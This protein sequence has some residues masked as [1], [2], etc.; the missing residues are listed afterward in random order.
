MKPQVL[1]FVLLTLMV[2]ACGQDQPSKPR[3]SNPPNTP[4]AN[5]DKPCIGASGNRK[6]AYFGDLHTHT[7]FSLDA[8]FF[9]AT[10]DPRAAH[11]FAQ[12]KDG[13]LPTLGSDDP[14]TP[15]R[16]VNIGRP[17][18]FNAVTDHAEFLGGF[19]N[20]C[21]RNSM[22]QKQCDERI[23]KGIRDDVI[24]IAAGN[25]SLQQQLLQSLVAFAPT[26]ISAWQNTKQ[27]NDDEYVPCK[28]TTLHAYEFTSNE[29]SQMFH[30]NVIFKGDTTRIPLI[31]FPAVRPDT[32]LNPQNGNDDWDLFDHLKIVCKSI[33]GCDVLTIPHNGNLSDGRMWLPMEANGVPLGRKIDSTDIYLPM[34]AADASLRRSMDVA[35]E[36]TQHKGQSECAVGLEGP[37][38]QGEETACTFETFKTVC[39][40]RA[41]DPA[42]CAKFCKGDP[43]TDPNFCNHRSLGDN[44][45]DTC[46]NPGP[47]G[48]SRPSRNPTAT[49]TG[50]CTSALDYYRYAMAE[51]LAIRKTLGINPY[52]ANIVAASDTHNGISGNVGERGFVGHGGVLDDEPKELLGFWN[53]T[54]GGDPAD[55]T[56][57]VG[58]KFQDFARTLNP[59]GLTGVWA[60]QNKRNEIWDAIHRGESW[61]TSGPRIKIR[62]IGGWKL[63][64]NTCDR[65]AAGQNP[66][67]LGETPGALMGGDLPLPAI[68]APQIAVWA[69]Q[70]P[71][72]YPLQRIDIVKGY[73]DASGKP[74]VKVFENVARTKE[75]VKRPSMTDCSVEIGNHPEQL[76]AI[77]KD[78]EFNPSQDAYYYARALEVPSCRWSSYMC[79]VDKKVD[80]SLLNPV[81]G[82][83]P[84]S[85]GF[86]GYEGCCATTGT[87]GSFKGRNT[88]NTIEER[89]WASPIWYEQKLK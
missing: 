22:L 5:D 17:L 24:N 61:G 81:N 25:T 31:V 53:C 60:T 16:A 71:E 51:G 20:T 86:S 11:E 63:P 35:V 41:D 85:T 33:P 55:P 34:T 66:V 42:T 77:W 49:G 54:G 58:R 47:D 64:A 50:N 23:G 89:A 18:D 56:K 8:Y 26:S 46:L 84:A 88:F 37:Y 80:C 12:G 68:G 3:V 27:I 19:S 75:T 82:M 67:D 21:G 57:C 87:T 32:A 43:L 48:R 59:G 30:R 62:S 73:V 40:G 28:F 65:L 39:H 38:L 45:V 69:Q 70:D 78:P 44:I 76:C 9:N 2:S 6:Q 4:V 52:K 15:A 1:L 10:N 72:N 29:D 14:Y 36:L 79:N 7:A 83:F 13:H 74:R